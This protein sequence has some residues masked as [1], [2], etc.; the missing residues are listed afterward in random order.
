MRTTAEVGESPLRVGRDMPV[1]KVVDELAL[2]VLPPLT[3]LLERIV[4]GDGVL[5]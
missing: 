5:Y 3:E 1:L 2:I 4:F